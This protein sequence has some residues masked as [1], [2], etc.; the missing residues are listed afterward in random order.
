MNAPR[1]QCSNCTTAILLGCIS[2]TAQMFADDTSGN[3]DSGSAAPAAPPINFQVLQATKIDLGNRSMIYNLVA[4]PVIPPIPATA[5]AP[6]PPPPAADANTPQQQPALKNVALFFSATVYDR[7][8]TQLIWSDVN[9]R[10]TAY[11]NVDFN[12]FSGF[13]TLTTT[14]TSYFMVMG[15]VNS[16]QAQAASDNVQIP[17]LPQFNPAAAQYVL[18]QDGSNPPT[19]DSLKWL[20]AMHAYFGANSQ[21]MI[22]SY[23][24]AQAAQA[25]QAQWLLA[26]PPVPQDTTINLWPINSTNYQTAPQGGQQ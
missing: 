17:I 9:G 10:H 2:L 23:N 4:P 15:L 5:P 21:Q 26:H 22:D 6:S 18:A 24:A 12:Y 19:D 13:I 11:S 20:D 7:G 16:T 1:Q 25:A 3:P 14:D 8:V